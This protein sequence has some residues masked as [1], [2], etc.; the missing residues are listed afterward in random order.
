MGYLHWWKPWFQYPIN[1]IP[2]II[3][4]IYHIWFPL[5]SHINMFPTYSDWFWARWGPEVLSHVLVIASWIILSQP[6][7]GSKIETIIFWPICGFVWKSLA[8]FFLMIYNDSELFRLVWTIIFHHFSLK[9]P[10]V[11]DKFRMFRQTHGPKTSEKSI[12]Q[13]RVK[14]EEFERRLEPWQKMDQ[15][16]MS[17][18]GLHIYIYIFKYLYTYIHTYIYI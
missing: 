9:V 2:Y 6:K 11:E 16:A 8:P 10:Y 13:D 5:T 4:F 18:W 3:P 14:L 7:Q 12:G 15:Y 17:S 1:S